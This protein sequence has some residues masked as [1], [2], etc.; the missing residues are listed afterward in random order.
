MKDELK[1]Q[2]P[3]LLGVWPGPISVDTSAS[4]KTSAATFTV[5]VFPPLSVDGGGAAAASSTTLYH[6]TVAN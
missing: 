6:E 4:A 5:I 2:A 1:S 3:V